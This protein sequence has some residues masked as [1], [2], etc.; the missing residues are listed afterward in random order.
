MLRAVIT[1]LAP[2]FFFQVGSYK[3]RMGSLDHFVHLNQIYVVNVIKHVKLNSSGIL[4]FNRTL[5]HSFIILRSIFKT[6][7]IFMLIFMI[8]QYYLLNEYNVRIFNHKKLY[9]IQA[10]KKLSSWKTGGTFDWASPTEQ[11]TQNRTKMD[12]IL[13]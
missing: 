3:T 4:N 2:N 11:R 6:W 10:Y 1:E 12:F 9:F 13:N 8:W 7:G 5:S